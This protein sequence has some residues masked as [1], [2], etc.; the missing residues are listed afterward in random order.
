V[1]VR[2]LT[3]DAD[4]GRST[5][6]EH[7]EGKDDL[8]EHSVARLLAV[9]AAAAANPIPAAALLDV[10]THVR[11]ERAIASALLNG[12]TRAILI[13]VLARKLERHLAAVARH[14]AAPPIAPLAF[15]ALSLAHAQL[16]SIDAWLSCDGR[17]DEQMAT[18]VLHAITR[19][20]VVAAFGTRVG[21]RRVGTQ[22][23]E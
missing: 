2:E 7:F 17:Y 18:R 21:L 16:A 8:L 23:E 19:A 11:A 13:R 1:S 22:P 15:L 10:L 20:G 4:V 3:A 9:L 14:S 5:F 6:Y 12:P